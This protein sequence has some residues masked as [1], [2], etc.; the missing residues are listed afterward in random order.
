MNNKTLSSLLVAIATFVSLPSAQLS[1]QGVS[2]VPDRDP[3]MV[4]QVTPVYSYSLRRDEIVGKV[5]VSFV[6]TRSGDVADATIVSSTQKR[7]EKPTL[8]AMTKWKFAPA[9]KAGTPVATRM[10]QTV[11]Y[12][13]PDKSG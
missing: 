8:V 1:A 7:L 12:S 13:M 2:G 10:L 6:V 3:K 4:S 11:I 5:V 9:E